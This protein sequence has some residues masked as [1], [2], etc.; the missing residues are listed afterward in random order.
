M[1]TKKQPDKS[2]RLSKG[3]ISGKYTSLLFLFSHGKVLH[4]LRVFA[5]SPRRSS[6]S[7]MGTVLIPLSLRFS[8]KIYYNLRERQ[9]D[10]G[11]SA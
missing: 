9:A 8:L 5:A 4:F 6:N 2:L 3:I 11:N 10:Y 7:R 1:S